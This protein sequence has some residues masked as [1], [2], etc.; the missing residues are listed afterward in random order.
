MVVSCVCSLVVMVIMDLS[1]VW[2]CIYCC[3]RC[4]FSFRIHV[5]V[6]HVGGM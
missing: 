6:C 5:Y 4:I 1:R 2:G 3:T